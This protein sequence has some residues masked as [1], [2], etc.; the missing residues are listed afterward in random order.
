MLATRLRDREA[1]KTELSR[2]LAATGLKGVR[3]EVSD[4]PSGKS[5]RWLLRPQKLGGEFSPW[6]RFSPSGR[7]VNGVTWEAH[8]RVMAYMF[9]KFPD[10]TLKTAL[11]T[12]RGKASFEDDHGETYH[13]NAVTMMAPAAFGAL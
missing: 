11:A 12:Y 8:R 9:E 7:R 4:G 10:H 1:Y 5:V 3:V 13:K 6:Q 2:S